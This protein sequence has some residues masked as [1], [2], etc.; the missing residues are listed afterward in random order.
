MIID[1]MYDIVDIHRIWICITGIM[2]IVDIR[3]MCTYIYIYHEYSTI[4]NIMDM[5]R[6]Y[7]AYKDSVYFMDIMNIVDIKN[8]HRHN[9]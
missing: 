8:N 6:E 9:G 5:Y 1:I 7:S 2:N 4:P 3:N